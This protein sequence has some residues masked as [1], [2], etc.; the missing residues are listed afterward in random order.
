MGIR[1]TRQPDVR[2]DLVELADYIARDN[3]DAA[4][5]FLDAAEATFAFLAANREAG[6]LCAFTNERTASMRVWPI[7][8]FRNYLVFYRPIAEGVDV[9]RVLHGARNWGTLFADEN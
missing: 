2:R 9:V 1:V 5:R 8:G 4:L 3:L 6:Q 7:E